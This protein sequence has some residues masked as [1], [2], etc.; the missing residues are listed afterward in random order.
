MSPARR[1]LAQALARSP[2]LLLSWGL[3][4]VGV[5]DPLFVPAPVG[6][7]ARRRGRSA[8]RPGAP[9]RDAGKDGRCLRARRGARRRGRPRDRRRA[10]SPRRPEPVPRRALRA[11]Q[12]PDPAVD[13]ARVRARRDAGRGLRRPP[14]VLPDLVSW[15]RA[16]CGTSTG[17]PSGSRRLDGGDVVAALP[18]GHPA[19]RAAGG[20]RRDAASGSSTACS[21][22][23]SS[24]CSAGSAGM[25]FL[26]VSLANAFRRAGAVRRHGARARSSRSAWSSGSSASTGARPLALADADR[27]RAATLDGRE[28]R[29]VRGRPSGRAC[30]GLCTSRSV[31]CIVSIASTF[32]TPSFESSGPETCWARRMA[33]SGH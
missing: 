32:S 23:S 11:A 28:L 15:W 26:L 31:V 29:R 5:I 12:D 6:G 16:A 27:P 25:G 33:S 30:P 8:R 7:A 10:L 20:A 19:R 22:S 2:G 17:R 3:P 21:G 13:P 14:G 18:E 9:R 4:R 24:R 1:R